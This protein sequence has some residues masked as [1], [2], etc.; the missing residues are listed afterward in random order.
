MMF[1]VMRGNP[2]LSYIAKLWIATHQLGRRN[3]TD[4]QRSTVSNDVR[5]IRSEIEKKE[6]AQKAAEIV[7]KPIGNKGLSSSV[8]SA[9]KLKPLESTP[10]DSRKSVAKESKLPERKIRPERSQ[11][12]LCD[13]QLR[14][15]LA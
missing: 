13:P 14:A 2:V 10:K 6:R 4:D 8:K 9:D 11:N 5:E 15:D 7:H 1:V 3:L 12:R